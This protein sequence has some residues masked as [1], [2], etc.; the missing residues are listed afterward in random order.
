MKT[1]L[2]VDDD[3]AIL[4]Q[5]SFALGSHYHILEAKNTQEAFEIIEKNHID[6]ALVDLG[7]PPFENTHREGRLIITKLLEESDAKIL[8]L[9]GQEDKNYPKELIKMGIFDYIAKPVEITSLL[10]SLQRASFFIDNTVTKEDDTV[11]L[12]F[13][14]SLEDG[15]KGSADKA[16]KELLTKV[17]HQTHFNINQT[18]KILG[19][20]REN[21]YYFLKK[22]GIERPNND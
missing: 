7:L 17:L 22:F 21:C 6:I 19:I 1:L 2:L 15:L 16:Q 9:T 11:T 8:V 5:L 3:T 4:K 12:L 18:A 20:S 14:T 10:N 13:E